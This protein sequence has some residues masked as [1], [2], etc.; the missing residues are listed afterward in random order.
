[1]N[2][3]YQPFDINRKKKEDLE[4]IKGEIIT[5][6][7]L[8]YVETKCYMKYSKLLKAFSILNLTKKQ[9]INFWKSVYKSYPEE[10][11]EILQA[12]EDKFSNGLTSKENMIKLINN[13][14]DSKREKRRA[15]IALDVRKD[16]YY[17]NEEDKKRRNSPPYK[18]CEGWEER[19]LS[20]MDFTIR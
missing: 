10:W 18:G 14:H 16:M 4:Y 6:I 8:P 11:K 12:I 20:R 19:I 9:Y 17:G 13:S 3:K 1:M 5:D 7:S 2:K 15:L